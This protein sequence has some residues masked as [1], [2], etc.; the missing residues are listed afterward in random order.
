MPFYA[1]LFPRNYQWLGILT[2]T[3]NIYKGKLGVHAALGLVITPKV[4]GENQGWQ[5]K[6]RDV[7]STPGMMAGA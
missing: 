7:V 2:R 5:R 3:I 1:H 6:T 4:T